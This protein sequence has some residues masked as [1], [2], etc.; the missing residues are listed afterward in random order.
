MAQSK[1]LSKIL[2]SSQAQLLLIAAEFISILLVFW[3][4][5]YTVDCQMF[6]DFSVTKL[7][8]YSER[9]SKS[10]RPSWTWCA[11][12]HLSCALARFEQF[13]LGSGCLVWQLRWPQTQL[14]ED[15]L[16]RSRNIL[17]LSR[18]NATWLTAMRW[19]Y[20]WIPKDLTGCSA[21]VLQG[22]TWF[23]YNLVGCSAAMMLV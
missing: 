8:G 20:M 2:D 4:G 14:D 18:L 11:S 1:Q 3:C 19:K 9:Y 13:Y 10:K 7:T 23:I 6:A 21:A 22:W 16:N 17:T 5:I 12:S 15:G